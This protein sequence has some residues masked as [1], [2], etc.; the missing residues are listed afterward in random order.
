MLMRKYTYA[1]P[2]ATAANAA[3]GASASSTPPMTQHLP[4]AGQVM[5]GEPHIVKRG[6]SACPAP[7]GLDGWGQSPATPKRSAGDT[8]SQSKTRASSPAAR[9][10]SGRCS[11]EH[12][13]LRCVCEGVSPARSG[14]VAR[15]LKAV[16]HPSA[17]LCGPR[18]AGEVER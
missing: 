2:G 7:A 18:P 3:C 5:P 16:A 10:P 9:A 4:Q 13:S 8:P 1:S 12:V 14:G 11:G 17:Q 6:P 15:M